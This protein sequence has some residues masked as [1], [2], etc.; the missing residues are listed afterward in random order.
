MLEKNSIEATTI[1]WAN[2]KPILKANKGDKIELSW[3]NKLC[4]KFE[5]PNPWIKPKIATRINLRL[6]N[7]VDFILVSL[8]LKLEK[9]ENK[10]VQGIKNS[11]QFWEN[12]IHFNV[13]KAKVNE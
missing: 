5:K 9:A 4:K 6:D 13:A 1:I 8:K 3:P 11:T 2:S 12:S 7:L 10:M